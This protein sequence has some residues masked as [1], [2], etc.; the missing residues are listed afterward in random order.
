MTNDERDDANHSQALTGGGITKHRAFVARI[1]YLS[2]DRPDLK[3]AAM[4]V[5]CAVA[6]PSASDLE[7]VKRIRRYLVENPRAEC[8]LH[9]L[10]SVDCEA[11]S[12][13]A[14]GRRQKSPG[15]RCQLE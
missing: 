14:W 15:G 9:W 13:A 8:L 5:C 3:F 10:Q 11:F 7:R 2:Q 4:Q 12:D 1:G 6:N